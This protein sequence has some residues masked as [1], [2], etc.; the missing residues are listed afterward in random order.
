M[1]L[2]LLSSRSILNAIVFLVAFQTTAQTTVASF[3]PSS[4]PVGSS[5]VILGGSFNAVPANNIV[6]FGAV[7]ATVSFASVSSLTVTVPF[8]STYQPISVLNIATGLTGYSSRPFIITFTNPA[9]IGIPANFYKPKIDFTTGTNP[10]NVATADLD[11]DG[12]PDLVVANGN[13]NTL[14]ILRNISTTG[15]I[16]VSSFAAKV[17]FSS[18]SFTE[19]V[20]IGDVDGDGKP[21]LVVATNANISVLRNTSTPGIINATSFAAKVDFTSGFTS[22]IFM[23]IADV[24]GDGKPE[25]I[26]ANSTSNSVSVRRNLSTTGSINFA[27]KVDFTTGSTPFS[28]AV[29]D[30]DG[31]SKPDIAVANS[32]TGVNT[33]SVLR[34]TSVPGAISFVAKVDY[35]T[36]ASPRSVSLGDLDGDGKPD[37][38]VANSLASPVPSETISVLHNT[39][40]PGIINAGS[41]AAKVDFN[42]GTVPRFVN[43]ADLDGDAKPDLVVANVNSNNISVLRNTSA[44]GSITTGSFAVKANFTTGLGPIA[45]GIADMDGDA[46]PEITTAN[47]NANSVSIFQVDLLALP[48]TLTRFIAYQKNAGIQ[49][50]WTTLQEINMVRYEV[51]RSLNG[52]Q[53]TVVGT[54]AATGNN[55]GI[56]AYTFFDSRPY[57]GVSYYRI[58]MIERG[59]PKYSWTSKVNVT[60]KA[61]NTVSIFP[62]PI[63]ENSIALQLNLQKGNYM[64]SLTNKQGQQIVTKAINHAGGYASENLVPVR[65]IAA[66]VYLVRISG[67]GINIIKKIVKL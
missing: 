16:T 52:Q 59:D 10:R 41:F 38:V 8:G 46:I 13:S 66:G 47:G 50:E 26:N 44:P 33:V 60:D 43:I 63:I 9:G 12:K 29:G 34:N 45:V 24:D 15:N 18:G 67:R 2:H 17:D 30:L 1:C 23:A 27:P 36:G 5:V 48:V 61:E 3:A 21:D 28:I 37:L 65:P 51:E 56:A 31:D 7:Q 6:Y 25:L 11:G 58:K 53:F 64:I 14:S 55:S 62:H 35:I 4:G 22:P 39:S 32:A 42:C 54:T 57:K 49:V 40:S 20:A 19:Y